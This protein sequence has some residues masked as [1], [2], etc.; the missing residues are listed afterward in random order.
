[1]GDSHP[2]DWQA[3]ASEL[4]SLQFRADGSRSEFGSRALALA[5]VER[6]VGAERLASAVDHYIAGRPG[7][8]LAR[9]I[10]WLLHPWAC[11]LRCREVFDS[12]E[13]IH[14]RRSAVEL[15][16]VVADARA[17]P[18]VDD[19]LADPDPQI[20]SWGILVI[21]QLLMGDL[22]DREA[23]EPFLARARLHPNEQVRAAVTRIEQLDSP[24]QE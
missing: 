24:A 11:M 23:C 13:D 1:M 22:A 19:F 21:D 15:L 10:L 2:I 20:Q 17:L 3:L 12:S 6:L 9:S 14:A 8:E 18:W 7:S 4:S 16:R 5:A